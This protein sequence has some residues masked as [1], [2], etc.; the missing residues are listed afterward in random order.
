MKNDPS[1]IKIQGDNYFKQKKQNSLMNSD[2]YRQSL[3]SAEP[4]S[5]HHLEQ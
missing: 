3:T 2:D 1:A 4:N 5:H